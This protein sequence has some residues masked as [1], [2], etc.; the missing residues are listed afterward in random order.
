M[1]LSSCCVNRSKLTDEILKLDGM[2]SPKIRHLLNNLICQLGVGNNSVRYLEIGTWKGTSFVSALY[3]NEVERAVVI[4]NWCH[5]EWGG[6]QWPELA[7]RKARRA[8]DSNISKFLGERPFTLFECDVFSFPFKSVEGTFNTYFY[9]ANHSYAAHY[10]AIHC[11]LPIL[12]NEFVLI[13]DDFDDPK[14]RGGTLDAVQ[15]ADLSV[16]E[17]LTIPGDKEYWNGIFIARLSKRKVCRGVDYLRSKNVWEETCGADSIDYGWFSH[18][19][20][21]VFLKLVKRKRPSVMIELGS[22]LG[23]STKWF[24][25]QV[26][27]LVVIA[28]DKWDGSNSELLSFY[29]QSKGFRA[30]VD[31]MMLLR[32]YDVFKANCED[33]KSQ[34]IPIRTT[35]M[36]GLVE[37][38][39]AGVAPDII[40]VDAGHGFLDVSR[41]VATS[42]NLFPDAMIFGDDYVGEVKLAVDR[43]A[44]LI[45]KTVNVVK[46][47]WWY[48]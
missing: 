10:F 8:F 22:F 7:G 19:N 21:G 31:P 32:M 48:S 30:R 25:S 41:D 38:Y 16:N 26:P 28:I 1:T 3:G 42:V 43:I 5:V 17:S 20:K 36:N 37:V 23:K 24:A 40:Y 18:T 45:G 9:D 15:Y 39:R 29:R 33:F 27:G 12:E 6:A 14:V 46:R 11:Y 2:S 4:D 47:C 34:I 35:T 44:K 13:V